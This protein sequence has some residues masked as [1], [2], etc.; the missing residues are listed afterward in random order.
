[1]A[2][3]SRPSEPPSRSAWLVTPGLVPYGKAYRAMH[4]LAERRSAGDIPDTLILLEHPPVYT[5]GRRTDAAH[6][7]L[8]EDEVARA[9]AELHVVD[10][11]GS[12]T[13]HGPGQL[14]GYPI[15][16]L[17][18]APDVIRYLRRIEEA[19]IMACAD[20]G[21]PVGRSEGH[22]GV[23]AGERKVC[24]I[25]VKVSR[26]VTLHGFA[27]NCATDLA[28]FGGIVP[29]GLPDRG[30]TT[31]SELAGRTIT[32]DDALPVVA[33]RFADVFGR[34]LVPA[35]EWVTGSLPPARP[36]T[37]PAPA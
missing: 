24:A 34:E 6:L 13:F 32:V 5:A 20:L 2:E 21:V 36:R 17:G 35:P 1:M 23:W 26:G 4:E 30:V 14:V 28:W 31:L 11:G 12:V 19:I 3:T 8:D 18:P 15:L 29:C 9:G 37:A 10:R 33:G 22:T 7:L 27:L 25:G 16:H